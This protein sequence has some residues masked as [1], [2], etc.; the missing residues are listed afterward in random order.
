M[1]SPF[2]LDQQLESDTHHVTDLS[3]SR[4]LLMND[5][6]YPWLILVPRVADIHEVF[7]LTQAQ[8][9]ELWS[10]VARV[11]KLLKADFQP[12]KIN[13]GA[14]GNI[15]RQLHIHIVARNT[16]D[17]AWPGPV[18]GAAPAVAYEQTR[19]QSLVDSIRSQLAAI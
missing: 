5:S 6:Q 10:E 7:E 8:Q 18:W 3:L 14:L 9:H 4:L 17:A 13:I 16:D 11:S 12:E 2:V 15:V 1:S 19:A